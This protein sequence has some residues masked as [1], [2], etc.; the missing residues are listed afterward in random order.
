MQDKSGTANEIKTDSSVPSGTMT[1][2]MEKGGTYYFYLDGSKAYVYA[3]TLE[4]GT[5]ALDWSTVKAPELATPTV[6]G[7]TVKVPYTAV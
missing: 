4:K 2:E 6:D 5:P 1:F 3:I 7:D